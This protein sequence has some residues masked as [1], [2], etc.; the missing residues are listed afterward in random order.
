MRGKEGV[1]C[2]TRQKKGRDKGWETRG[3]QR[4]RWDEQDDR[5]GMLEQADVGMSGQERRN[6]EIQ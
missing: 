3:Q 2:G 1:R 4:G 5:E 6:E